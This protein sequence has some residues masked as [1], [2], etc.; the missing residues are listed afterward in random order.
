MLS[1]RFRPC[2][3]GDCQSPGRGADRSVFW[4]FR[5]SFLREE[6]GLSEGWYNTFS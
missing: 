6:E 4:I 3:E 1:A 2:F 5:L